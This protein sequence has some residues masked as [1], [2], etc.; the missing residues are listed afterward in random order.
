MDG[1]RELQASIGARMRKRKKQDERSICPACWKPG[2]LV[3]KSGTYATWICLACGWNNAAE[4][5]QAYAKA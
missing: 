3:I 2:T 4:M 5:K 1:I